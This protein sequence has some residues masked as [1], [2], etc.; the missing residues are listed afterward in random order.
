MF[1]ISA[2][3]Y[4]WQSA[5]IYLQANYFVIL[6]GCFMSDSSAQKWKVWLFVSIHVGELFTNMSKILEVKFFAFRAL[7]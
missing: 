4:D 6:L 1:S 3:A 5:Y 2:V 7:I